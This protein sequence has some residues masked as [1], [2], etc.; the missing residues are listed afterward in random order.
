MGGTISRIFSPGAAKFMVS[1]T[2][3]ALLKSALQN[4]IKAVNNLNNN[5]RTENKLIAMMNNTRIGLT[6]SYKKRIANAIASI[7]AKVPRVAAKAAEAAA[8]AAP[9]TPAAVAVNNLA[10]KIKN[11]NAFINTIKGGNTAAQVNAYIAGGRN[12]KNNRALNAGR[13]A[14]YANLFNA[15]NIAQLNKKIANINSQLPKGAQIT[16]SNRAIMYTSKYP[17]NYNINKAINKNGKYAGLWA[18]IN[19]VKASQTAKTFEEL[20][21]ANI[22][23]T[24]NAILPNN[25]SRKAKLVRNSGNSN[26]RFVNA[27]NN[28]KYNIN[29]KNM[30]N[31]VV[32]LKGKGVPYKSKAAAQLLYN[33]AYGGA[34]GVG[35]KSGSWTVNKSVQNLVNTNNKMARFIGINRAVVNANLNARPNKRQAQRAKNVLNAIIQKQKAVP[36]N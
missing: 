4:Y 33:Q 30:N 34:F 12:A 31:P 28:A 27:G 16:N 3:S 14:K 20:P 9:V 35:L 21:G 2:N 5:A 32:V 25:N 11:L 1:N 15:V 26:W 7:V 13:G 22:E 19:A 24:R 17:S 23:L 29:K 6:N 8:G 18:A 10:N 36:G